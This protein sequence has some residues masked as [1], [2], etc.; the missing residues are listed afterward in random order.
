MRFWTHYGPWLGPKSIH[1]C[2]AYFLNVLFA[3]LVQLQPFI[4]ELGATARDAR[5]RQ[6]SWP[7]LVA[8]FWIAIV[9]LDIVAVKAARDLRKIA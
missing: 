4:F 7:I 6:P 3:C 9:N 5:C 1:M 8:K 2:A